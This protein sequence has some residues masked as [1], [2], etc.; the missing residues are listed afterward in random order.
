VVSLAPKIIGAESV[1]SL[2]TMIWPT[3]PMPRH[4][5]RLARRLRSVEFRSLAE[6]AVSEGSVPVFAGNM[7]T[8]TR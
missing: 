1:I 7:M 2:K 8:V 4:E 6:V 3:G 5:R